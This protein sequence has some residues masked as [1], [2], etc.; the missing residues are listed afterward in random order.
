MQKQG[1]FLELVLETGAVFRI[2]VLRTFQKQTLFLEPTLK[3]IPVF[4]SIF[5]GS[6]SELRNGNFPF[7]L[8][9]FPVSRSFCIFRITGGRVFRNFPF[10]LH[11]PFYLGHHSLGWKRE[12]SLTRPLQNSPYKSTSGQLDRFW[13]Q[14]P[15]SGKPVAGGCRAKVI[16]PKSSE[17]GTLNHLEKLCDHLEL[18]DVDEINKWIID[19]RPKIAT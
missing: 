16:S 11:F 15:K 1:L 19:E 14:F 7:L 10:L 13:F 6:S 9:G 5:S 12:N 8:P 3:T 4:A 18:A 17:P 2:S